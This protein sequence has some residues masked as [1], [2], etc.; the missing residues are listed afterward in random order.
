MTVRMNIYVRSP[1]CTHE[2]S[3]ILIEVKSC[4]A[5]L[6]TLPI[7]VAIWLQSVMHLEADLNKTGNARA[8]WPVHVTAVVV[9][10]QQALRI[11]SVYL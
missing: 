7:F 8:L 10:K 2:A 5:L 11:V 9:E 6:L 3:A 4:I 1:L